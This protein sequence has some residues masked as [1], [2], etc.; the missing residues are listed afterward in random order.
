MRP[1]VPPPPLLLPDG[2]EA[3]RPRAMPLLEGGS[4]QNGLAQR[5]SGRIQSLSVSQSGSQP[6]EAPT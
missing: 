4:V 3:M 6:F 1:S 5:D 2:G